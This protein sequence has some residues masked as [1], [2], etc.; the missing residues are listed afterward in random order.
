[1][2]TKKFIQKFPEITEQEQLSN[3]VLDSIEAGCA[4]SCSQGC[5]RK[6]MKNDNTMIESNKTPVASQT[7][8]QLATS[9]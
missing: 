7:A 9:N 3:E 1:M 2:E 5:K 6:N 4:E 8:Q